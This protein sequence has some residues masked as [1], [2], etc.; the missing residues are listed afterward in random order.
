MTGCTTSTFGGNRTTK[1]S[2]AIQRY[3]LV[4]CA[5]FA[6][7]CTPT[8]PRPSTTTWAPAGV[9]RLSARSLTSKAFASFGAFFEDHLLSTCFRLRGAVLLMFRSIVPINPQKAS[10]I[11]MAFMQTERKIEPIG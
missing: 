9:N 3:P 1:S 8:K 7:S 2:V 11:V 10:P 6:R 4:P 5:P